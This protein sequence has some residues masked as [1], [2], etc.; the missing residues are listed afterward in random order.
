MFILISIIILVRLPGGKLLARG[1]NITP[2]QR[3]PEDL[4]IYLIIY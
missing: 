2:P 1:L 3:Q 4:F